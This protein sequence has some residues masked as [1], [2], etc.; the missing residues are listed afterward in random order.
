MWLPVILTEGLTGRTCG[1]ATIPMK[2]GKAQIDLIS[3]GFQ[4]QDCRMGSSAIMSVIIYSEADLQKLPHYVYWTKMYDQIAE[5]ILAVD[6]SMVTD[7][8]VQ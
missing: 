8:V 2:D 1:M 6:I 5:N 3:M 4:V 7:S